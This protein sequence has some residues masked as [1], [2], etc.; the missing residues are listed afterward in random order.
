MFLVATDVL[1]AL[2]KRRSHANVEAWIGRQRT[3]DLF[4]SVVSIGE[5]E[6]GIALQRSKD[7]HFPR[8]L[9]TGSITFST[10]MATGF[11]RLILRPPV[12]GDG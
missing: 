10:F 3:A 8:S 7:R 4:V 1:S 5:I 12:V 2:S 6:R 11:C 9:R